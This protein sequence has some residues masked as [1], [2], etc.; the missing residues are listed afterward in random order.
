M[1]NSYRVISAAA[2]RPLVSELSD[3]LT[4]APD[5]PTGKQHQKKLTIFGD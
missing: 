5:F 3:S 2:A 1:L 4:T